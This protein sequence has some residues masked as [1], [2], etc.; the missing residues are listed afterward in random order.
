MKNKMTR[1]R[2]NTIN[3]SG[4]TLIELLISM[5]ITVVAA[6]G[7]FSLYQNQQKT[8]MAQK[9][10]V[11]MQQTLRMA[12]YV[13]TDEI[14]LAGYDPEGKNSAGILNAGDGS[15][16]NPLTFTLVAED[17]GQDND[18][19]GTTD[20]KG[21]LKTI[22]YDLYF[23]LGD[24][25]TDIG[26]KVGNG[27]RMPLAENIKDLEFEYFDEDGTSISSPGTDDFPDIRSVRITIEATTD[28]SKTNNADINNRIL[29]TIVKFRNLGLDL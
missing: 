16:G 21:E 4:F 10:V 6:T 15:N 29:T 28:I 12:L 8:Q 24:G 19:D 13:M 27:N 5:T 7:I 20:E 2:K 23:G 18:N 22:G 26:R 1:F 11:E 9:Q 14:R 17:D 3:N 25:D